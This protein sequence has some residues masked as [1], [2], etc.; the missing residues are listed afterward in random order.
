MV[1]CSESALGLERSLGLD[2]EAGLALS[3]LC[4]E[5]EENVGVNTFEVIVY[6]VDP[7]G[8]VV[9]ASP[10]EV[11]KDSL[12]VDVDIEFLSSLVKVVADEYVG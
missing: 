5:G 9:C 8:K 12:R 10:P 3:V 1:V 7:G 6:S 2:G 4:G 11:V